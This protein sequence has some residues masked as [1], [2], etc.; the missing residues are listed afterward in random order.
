MQVSE[1]C[2]RA[3]LPGALELWSKRCLRACLPP[4]PSSEGRSLCSH[5]RHHSAARR[6]GTRA[7]AAMALSLTSADVQTV[8]EV[9]RLF[10]E[11]KGLLVARPG[12]FIRPWFSIRKPAGLG[13][14]RPG[15]DA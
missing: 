14:N 3:R 1:A 7:S 13:R 9:T 15:S 6:S 12:R 8:G 2:A 11:D 5:S 4:L 10:G